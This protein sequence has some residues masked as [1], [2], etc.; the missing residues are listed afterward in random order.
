MTGRSKQ[1]ARP[2][3]GAR[4]PRR[5]V[6]EKMAR[7][8]RDLG[9]KTGKDVHFEQLG[10]PTEMDRSMVERIEDP[11][12]HMVRNAIDHAIEPAGEREAS[13]KP[14]HGTLRL[15]ARHE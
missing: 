6:L 12:I 14:R 2:P 7:L 11:L 13:G 4:E 3:R 15:A 9:R 1:R 8:T 10:D 5:G